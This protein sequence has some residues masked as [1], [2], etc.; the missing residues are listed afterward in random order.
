MK[1]QESRFKIY[2]NFILKLLSPQLGNQQNFNN[3]G[4]IKVKNK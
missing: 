2:L 3:F 4:V 1:I